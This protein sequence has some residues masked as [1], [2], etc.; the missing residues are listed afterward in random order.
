MTV[1][2]GST[3]FPCAV[4]SKGINQT[5]V[6]DVRSPLTVKFQNYYLHYSTIIPIIL[7]II[8]YF[9]RQ[10]CDS[11]QYSLQKRETLAG[12]EAGHLHSSSGTINV[13]C[14]VK[15]A[16]ADAGPAA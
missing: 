2:A 7:S 3:N 12:A 11:G 14:P 13:P 16:A 10:N 6:S 5:S 8:L 1:A 4:P 9:K 15:D